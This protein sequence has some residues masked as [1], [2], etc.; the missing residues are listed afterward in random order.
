MGWAWRS[1]F[2]WKDLASKFLKS[3]LFFSTVKVR[4]TPSTST[5][6]ICDDKKKS[7][8]LSVLF[9]VQFHSL[10]Y[11]KSLLQLSFYI[12]HFCS[13]S[14]YQSSACLVPYEFLKFPALF[15]LKFLIKV[16]LIK[17]TCISFIILLMLRIFQY[18]WE[19]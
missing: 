19:F 1:L 8:C 13:L 11:I 9:I 6:I 10:I 17:K 2:F 15:S 18:S 7:N 16:F 12:F 14:N 4:F 3:S 5:F